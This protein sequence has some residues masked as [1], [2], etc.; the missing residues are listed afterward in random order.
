MFCQRFRQFGNFRGESGGDRGVW[1][2][3]RIKCSE[4]RMRW[5]CGE[6]KLKLSTDF[7]VLEKSW[8]FMASFVETI[9]EKTASGKTAL[10]WRLLFF[11]VEINI[12]HRT[13]AFSTSP[14]HSLIHP[15]GIQKVKT[16]NQQIQP[17][18]FRFMPSLHMFTPY[19][20]VRNYHI[21]TILRKNKLFPQSHT[22]LYFTKRKAKNNLNSLL[23]Y[24][25]F[26]TI[27]AAKSKRFMF[28]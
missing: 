7:I 20:F 22:N 2:Y 4:I 5:S 26:S 23:Q 6:W 11:P 21:K 1:V 18:C 25:N 3:L 12:D 19:I 9:M 16:K 28:T 17:N 24:V 10:G 8:N 15:Y 13:M 27:K 14:P